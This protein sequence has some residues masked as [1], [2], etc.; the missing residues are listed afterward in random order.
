MRKFKN[1]QEILDKI[2]HLDINFYQFLLEKIEKY[3]K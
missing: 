1:Y 3:E 2:M